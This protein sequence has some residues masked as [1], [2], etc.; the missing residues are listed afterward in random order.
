[1]AAEIGL[2]RLFFCY[3][4]TQISPPME[5]EDQIYL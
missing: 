5:H 4:W 2:G 1:L 3:L